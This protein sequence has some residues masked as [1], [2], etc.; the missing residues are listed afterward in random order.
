MDEPRRILVVKLSGI[1]DL[2]TAV[3]ALK[4]LRQSFPLARIDL[5]VPPASAPLLE[6]SSL[7]DEVLAFDKYLYDRP[8]S[9]L[10]PARLRGAWAL[11]RRI[12]GAGYDWVLLMHHLTTRWGALKF[13]A[14]TLC[15]GAKRRAGLDNGRGRFLTDRVPDGGFGARHEAEYWSAIA[16]KMGAEVDESAIAIEVRQEAQE[17]MGELLRGASRPVVAIHAGTGEYSPARRWSPQGFAQVAETLRAEYGGTVVLVGGKEEVELAGQVAE[18]M[19]CQ[20]LNLAGK[21]NLRE[22]AALL[23]QCDLFIGNDSGVMHLAAAV[24]TPLV[25][26]FGPS[27]HRAWRPYREGGV[28]LVRLD[29]P[30]SPCLYV[31]PSVGRRWGC[32]EMSCMTGLGPEL[33]LAAAR[34]LLEGRWSRP[35]R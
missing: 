32:P 18:L 2:L 34:R 28:E 1:G 4:G 6:G 25:A 13:T 29:L 21:L 33:V 17:E 7:V 20:L 8:L 31:G 11:W 16:E 24:G 5:L 3:P 9:A 27:N 10:H 26:I 23:S 35:R 22:L 15:T 12:A 19:C 14:L 30:C